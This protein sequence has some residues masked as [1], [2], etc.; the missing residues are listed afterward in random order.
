MESVSL[1]GFVFR[2]VGS[3]VNEI[4]VFDNDPNS[5]V[6]TL[7][8]HTFGELDRKILSRILN[9]KEWPPLN[10]GVARTGISNLA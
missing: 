2:V 8:R 4:S 6:Q 7:F 9:S 1:S 10:L 3:V 5:P